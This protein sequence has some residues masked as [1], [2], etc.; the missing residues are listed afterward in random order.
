[1]PSRENRTAAV[2]EIILIPVRFF[3]KTVRS[4]LSVR[5][6]GGSLGCRC[7]DNVKI[8]SKETGY[9]GV[10]WIRLAQKRVQWGVLMKAVMNFQVP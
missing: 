2:S 8:D 3:L 9:E 4:F 7:E 1:V 5:K 10:D 6:P